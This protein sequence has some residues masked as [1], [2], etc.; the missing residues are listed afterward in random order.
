[1]IRRVNRRH[2]KP[3]K[4][5]WAREMRNNPTRSEAELW[6]LLRKSQLGVKFGR[7]RIIAGYIADFY[8]PSL[9][10]AVELDGPLHNWGYD[11]NR[12]AVFAR[13]GIVTLRF[14][15][16]RPMVEIVS[17]LRF[18]VATTLTRKLNTLE[19]SR[20]RRTLG[21]CGKL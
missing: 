17:D 6:Q 10:L 7:Q 12:D 15:S 8:C 4:K 16:D 2:C 11:R 19:S 5:I 3:I 9:G 1:M 20:S 14:P 21:N 13:L 18:A